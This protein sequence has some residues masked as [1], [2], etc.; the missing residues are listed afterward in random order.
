MQKK[1]PLHEGSQEKS[2]VFNMCFYFFGEWLYVLETCDFFIFFLND[3]N[4]IARMKSHCQI[5]S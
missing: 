1:L 3:I 4:D 5:I 2:L